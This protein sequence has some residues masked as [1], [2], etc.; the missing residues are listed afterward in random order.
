M[1]GGMLLRKVFL[2]V[3]FVWMAS[4]LINGVASGQENAGQDAAESS[5]VELDPIQDKS[6]LG[7]RGFGR[8]WPIFL[9]PTAD[10]K[11]IETGIRTDWTGGKLPVVWS[12]PLKMSYGICS[13]TQGR[14]LQF[15]AEANKRS[16]STGI[17]HCRHSETG[18]PIWTYRYSY[19]YDDTYNYNN[20]PRTSP[21]VD[22]SNV[23]GYGVDGTLFCLDLETGA[24][25]WRKNVSEQFGV[26]QNFFGVGSN[27]LV[28]EDYLLVMV[29][30]SPKPTRIDLAKGN[31][32]GIVAF[33]KHTGKLAYQ[34]SDELASYSSLK[35]VKRDSRAWCFAWMRGGL[36]VFNPRNGEED[37]FFPWRAR[38]LES[39]NASVPVVIGN[40]VFIS[41]TYGPGSALLD[42]TKSTTE[43]PSIIWQDERRSRRK[44]MQTHWNT[45]V[46]H[47]GFLYGSS[48]RHA[49]DAELRCV[50]SDTGKVQWS[51][52][53]LSRASLLYV[54]NHFVCLDELGRLRLLAADPT[55]YREVTQ[56]ELQDAAGEPLLEYPAWAAPVLSH[57]LLYV[58]GNSRLVCLE[59]I[60][61]GD[62]D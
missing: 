8:D 48:G 10:N 1:F 33:N 43:V 27:P 19:K 4:C 61:P 21:I 6:D 49:S 38:I 29:G 9:G 15:D 39:V 37:F 35:V 55:A 22:G 54:D 30:G 34:L 59:L 23:Y 18:D 60:P 26:V 53:G 42:F 41:E 46:Y 17:V 57:G 5:P 3:C 11:S 12:M 20:G 28:Y 36:L 47:N 13:V 25:R 32:S 58:R 2:L 14:V 56:V 24:E 31:G 16:E 44:A 50:A 7:T 62:R 52:P 40:Q 51:Q 45:A